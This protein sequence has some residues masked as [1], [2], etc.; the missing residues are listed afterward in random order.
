[1]TWLGH[2]VSYGNTSLIILDQPQ[3]KEESHLAGLTVWLGQSQK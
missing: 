2:T 1:M 3:D